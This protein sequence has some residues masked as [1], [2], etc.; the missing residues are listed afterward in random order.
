[1]AR[2]AT[3]KGLAYMHLVYLANLK[4][5]QLVNVTK[6]GPPGASGRGKWPGWPGCWGGALTP[7]P[8]LLA[9]TLGVGAG[10]SGW[11]K[12][13]AYLVFVSSLQLAR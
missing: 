11:G 8:Q 12:K 1:M 7:R 10:T 5:K 3:V 9:P 6:N 2:W 4:A 13:G